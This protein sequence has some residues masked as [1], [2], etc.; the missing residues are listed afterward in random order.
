MPQR[1]SGN[2]NNKVRMELEL[3]EYKYHFEFGQSDNWT[4]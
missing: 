4:N 3:V 1:F 2:R